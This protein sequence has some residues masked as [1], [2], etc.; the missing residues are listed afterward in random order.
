S[1]CQ[2][3]GGVVNVR[4]VVNMVTD[5][6]EAAIVGERII[7]TAGQ[8][9]NVKVPYMGCILW[10]TALRD[11]VK[12]RR[13][14]LLDDEKSVSAQCFRELAQRITELPDSSAGVCESVPAEASFL[15]R[16]ARHMRKKENQ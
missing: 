6:H 7:A 1:L 10:D 9:L 2:V 11:A 8:F 4:I 14:L 5:E 13:P 16:L 15:G 3:T 12:R